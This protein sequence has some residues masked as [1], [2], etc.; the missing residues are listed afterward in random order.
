MSGWSSFCV[1]YFMLQF[2]FRFGNFEIC[3][4][5]I[6]CL[7]Q[8]SS[9]LLYKWCTPCPPNPLKQTI[10]RNFW[11]LSKHDWSSQSSQHVKINFWWSDS[12]PTSSWPGSRTSGKNN[13]KRAIWSSDALGE[14]M[15]KHDVF[16]ASKQVRFCWEPKCFKISCLATTP[17]D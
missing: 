16:G 10:Y 2:A 11:S 1:Q 15:A 13:S 6:H 3:P 4:T 8:S 14:P 17:M 7:G 9:R 5:S 12:Q